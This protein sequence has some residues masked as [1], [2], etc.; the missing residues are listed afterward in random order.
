MTYI[1]KLIELVKSLGIDG[2]AGMDFAASQQ[3]IDRD[4]ETSCQRGK[5]GRIEQNIGRKTN[6]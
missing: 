3:R 1:E 6:C 2:T 4:T 5:R